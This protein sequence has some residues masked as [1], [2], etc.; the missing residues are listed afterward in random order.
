MTSLKIP[1]RAIKALVNKAIKDS[2]LKGY[3]WYLS[4]SN[5]HWSYLSKEYFTIEIG[6]V[7][8]PSV[9]VIYH[10][11]LIGEETF[12]YLLIGH[13]FYCECRT[14]DSGIYEAVKSTIN[15]AN[16]TF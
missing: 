6:S 9:K 5:L 12:I 10:N 4:G 7:E 13:D 16:N 2:D 14:I 11:D 1:Q 15:K 8:E 3:K